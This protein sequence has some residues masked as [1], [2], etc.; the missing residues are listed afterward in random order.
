MGAGSTIMCLLII[1]SGASM[2]CSTSASCA[3]LAASYSMG[4]RP[5][6][7]PELMLRILMIGCL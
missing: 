3:R 7:D 2:V 1:C 5:S 6:I 4:G